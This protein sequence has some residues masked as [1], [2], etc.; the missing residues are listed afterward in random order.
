MIQV[1]FPYVQTATIIPIF[2]RTKTANVAACPTRG[3]SEPRRGTRPH[4]WAFKLR[5]LSAS[6]N[7]D[8]FMRIRALAFAFTATAALGGCVMPP[9]R[10]ALPVTLGTNT[11]THP[12]PLRSVLLF[13]S[14]IGRPAAPPTAGANPPAADWLPR[15]ISK[16]GRDGPMWNFPVRGWV[17]A[18]WQGPETS[19][20]QLA[21]SFCLV[22]SAN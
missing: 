16:C 2:R 7:G 19:N 6:L 17:S 20:Y 9:P 22:S 8:V 10:L 5:S 4:G 15:R 18:V 11:A 14:P 1:C 13:A 21:A 12:S 3:C